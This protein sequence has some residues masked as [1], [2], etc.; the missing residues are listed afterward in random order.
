MKKPIH[1]SRLTG[2]LTGRDAV[3][4]IIRQL[5]QFS[6]ID[7]ELKAEAHKDFEK[8]NRATIRTYLTGL[9]AA[10]YIERLPRDKNVRSR[11]TFNLVKDIGVH[12]PRVNKKGESSSQGSNREQMWRTMRILNDFSALDLVAI[13]STEQVQINE[14]D[15]KN[16]LIHLNKAGYLKVLTPASNGGG[17]ARYRLLPAMN[18]GPKPPMVQRIKQVFDPNLNMVMWPKD[19]E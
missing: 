9:E 11:L 5:R 8:V 14:V 3:W 18:T 1:I 16:Y 2:K 15:A 17:L 10:G 19:G 4:T 7:I 13:A 6:I 12:A